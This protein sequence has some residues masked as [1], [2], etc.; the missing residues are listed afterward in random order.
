MIDESQTS[1]TPDILLFDN[2]K[3][4]NQVII[5]VSG[6]TGA[7]RDFEKIKQIKLNSIKE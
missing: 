1:P 4:Q 6:N 5:E 3:K 7:R 2:H